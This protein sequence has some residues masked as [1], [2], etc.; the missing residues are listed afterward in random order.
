VYFEANQ[1]SEKS[2]SESSDL[3]ENSLINPISQS[4]LEIIFEYYKI[5]S[6]DD[7]KENE[8]KRINEILEQATRDNLLDFWISE[9][10]HLLGHRLGLLDDMRRKSYADQKAMLREYLGI[11]PSCKKPT[12]ETSFFVDFAIRQTDRE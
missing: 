10:D 1:V 5:A 2:I 11:N 3:E 9:I 4:T 7:L 12:S 6:L 8:S